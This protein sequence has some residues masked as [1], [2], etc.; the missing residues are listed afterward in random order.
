MLNVL[1]LDR[2][3]RRLGKKVKSDKGDKIGTIQREISK[4]GTIQRRLAGCLG[5]KY[6][7]L[8]VFLFCFL[9]FST[10]HTTKRFSCVGR[11]SLWK[12]LNSCGSF[13]FFHFFARKMYYLVRF[14]PGA[15][16][17][18]RDTVAHCPIHLRLAAT[19]P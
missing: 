9:L 15:V 8:I 17:D 18:H 10:Q 14:S 12:K 3:A 13:H 11:A 5:K 1:Q 19:H 7:M 4:I 16:A 6:L 2:L